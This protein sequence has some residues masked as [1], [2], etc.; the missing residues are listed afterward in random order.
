MGYLSGLF[1]DGHERFL[2][3]AIG[4]EGELELICPS[5]TESQARR[6]GIECIQT[7]NDS[8]DPLSLF[9]NLA[10]RWNLRTGILAVDDAMRAKMLLDMQQ[11][12]P[13]ALFRPGQP[14]LAELMS[15]KT[16]AELNLLRKAGAIADSALQA[17]IEA[18]R[19]GAS[20]SAVRNALRAAMEAGGGKPT[21]T[22]V[23]TGAM[24][25]EPHHES[26]DTVIQ[27]GDVVIMDFGCDYQGY[28]SD[29]TRTVCCGRAS[30]EAKNVYDIVL[31][32][33][34]A[35]RNAIH[36]GVPCGNVDRAARD[37]IEAAGYGK[38]FVHRLGHGIGMQVHEEPY[39]VSGNDKALEAGNCFSIEPGIYLPGKLGV[40]IENIVT[41]TESGHESLN[42]EPSPTLLEIS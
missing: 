41:C 29:I 35:G 6:A 28:Q 13:A 1:E 16:D 17:G 10:D 34:Y 8:E 36:P 31:R 23:A 20:E 39:M 7:W 4:A 3:L 42:E 30:N 27:E 5:L 14:I 18:I 37:V 2:T 19:P 26:D 12:L 9:E 32:A 15:R 22:I 40:R 38:Y 25:A 33:H 11:T 24:G 21:F